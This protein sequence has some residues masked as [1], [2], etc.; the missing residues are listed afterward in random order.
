MTAR[1]TAATV[2]AWAAVGV[3]GVTGVAAAAGTLRPAAAPAAPAPTATP[4]PT[5]AQTKT[6][7][8]GQGRTG[9]GPGHR[10]AHRA[11]HGEFVVRDRAGGFRTVAVQRGTVEQVGATSIRLRS[12]DGFVRSY[13]VTGDTVV[14]T[15]RG[16]T[17]EITDVRT[18]DPA[19][20]VADR[21]GDG[22][23]AR[24]VFQRPER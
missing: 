17:G 23:R 3:L 8:A 2:V 18:G 12:G 22:Y 6:P 4:T 7:A 20:V 9:R 10:W 15:G 24:S 11:L 5:A 14:R 19:A 1:R 13:A 16:R 21:D